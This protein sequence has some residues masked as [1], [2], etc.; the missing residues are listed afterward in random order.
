MKE[1]KIVQFLQNQL[2]EAEKLEVLNWIE[3]TSENQKTFNELKNAWILGDTFGYERGA[4]QDDTK[5]IVK[6]H[7]HTTMMILIFKYAAIGL[8]LISIGALLY[9]Q[10]HKLSQLSHQINEYVVPN[11]QT[12]NIILCDGTT[13]YLNSGSVLKYSGSY[14]IKERELFLEGEA[15]FDVVS[16]KNKPFIV[17]TA[18]F[19][20]RA[21]GTSFNIQAYPNSDISDVTLVS[22]TLTVETIKDLYPIVLSSGENA[23]LNRNTNEIKLSKVEQNQYISWKE[24]IV[25]F[26]NARLEDIAMMLE[27][28]YNVK[29]LFSNEKTRNLR[30]NGT[31]LRYKPID[32]ILNIIELTSDIKFNIETRANEP[33]L[34]TIK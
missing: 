22:G 27:R 17:R 4:K 8:M 33:N 24:G 23:S 7:L 20:V 3:S 18:Q 16:N 32:Q 11:G 2:G 1:K 6:H 14:A 31:M 9:S 12:A 19:D 13:V 25:T 10:G 21:T 34:I 15:F 29:I 30:Y 26:R 28:T 5:Y